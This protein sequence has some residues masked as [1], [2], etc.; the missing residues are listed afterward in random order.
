MLRI[1]IDIWGEGLMGKGQE[2]RFLELYLILILV[3]VNS[4]KNYLNNYHVLLQAFIKLSQGSKCIC[5]HLSL[6][7]LVN[8][9]A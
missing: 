1:Y 9:L 4:Q 3:L 8:R 2:S 6:Q 5:T 7:F